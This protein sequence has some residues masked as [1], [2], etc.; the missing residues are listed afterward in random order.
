MY[1]TGTMICILRR[2]AAYDRPDS[3]APLDFCL[4]MHQHRA[5]RQ[6]ATEWQQPRNLAAPKRMCL[7]GTAG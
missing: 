6:H 5:H 4:R 1:R 7:R 2:A 3:T